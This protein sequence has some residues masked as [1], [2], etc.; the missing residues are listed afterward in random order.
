MSDNEV[1]T[2]EANQIYLW[3]NIMHVA[4]ITYYVIR[5]FR[6]VDLF[7]R[8]GLQHWLILIGFIVL[9]NVLAVYAKRKGGIMNPIKSNRL[10]R[11]LQRAGYISFVIG[12]LL[13]AVLHYNHNLKYISLLSIPLLIISIYYGYK[14]IITGDDNEIL[15]DFDLNDEQ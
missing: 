13:T 11:I 7:P 12:I 3:L 2:R 8:R 1:N 10:A 15:D 5:V 6:F 9:S 14:D 4:F